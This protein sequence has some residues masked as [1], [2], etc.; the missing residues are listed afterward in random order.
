MEGKG[1]GEGKGE[2]KEKEKE[3]GKGKGKEREK[4]EKK[5]TCFIISTIIPTITI[6]LNNNIAIIFIK[7]IPPT[8]TMSWVWLTSTIKTEDCSSK[9]N[10]FV[11][12]WLCLVFLKGKVR[13]EKKGVP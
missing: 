12:W 13:K 5:N 9:E 8:P 2:G 4:K 7:N 1:K 11:W 10:H 6:P 3:K